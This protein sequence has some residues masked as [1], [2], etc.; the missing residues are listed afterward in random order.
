MAKTVSGICRQDYKNSDE[1]VLPLLA[2]R[3]LPWNL[4][5]DC[6]IWA[7][8]IT[9]DQ[10]NNKRDSNLKEFSTMGKS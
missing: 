3:S 8:K 9:V 1:G 4:N 5:G 7:G 2:Q 6:D 10:G